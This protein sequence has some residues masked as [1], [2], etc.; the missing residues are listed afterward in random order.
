MSDEFL[1]ELEKSTNI[2]RTENN[3][4]TFQSTLN[5][6]LDWFSMS[7]GLRFQPEGR[8]ISLFMKAF[9]EDKQLAIKNLFF[10]RDIKKG[11]G[12][13]RVFRV[14][15][16][17]LAKTH[18]DIVRKN[19]VF[20]PFFGRWDDL[21]ELIDTP[22]ENSMW[23]FIKQQLSEDLKSENP[24]LLAKWLKSENTS[25][26]ESV[27]LAKKTRKA[28]S[29]TPKEYRKTLAELRKRID[30]LERRLSE[31]DYTFD[32][33]KVPSQAM[34]KY[35]KAFLRNDKDRYTQYIE[36]VIQGK[37]K[38][39]TNTLSAVQ[40]VRQ[41][42]ID[43]GK[44]SLEEKKHLDL[45]W[46]N[47]PKID[48]SENALVV[49]DTSGSMFYACG[50]YALGIAA[51]IGLALYYAENNKGIFHNRFITFSAKPKLQ[52]IQGKTIYE[53]V[54]FLENADWECNTDIEAVFT[55]I[56]NI[57][58]NKNLAQE[59]L[60]KKLYIVSDMEFDEAT[61]VSPDAPLFDAIRERY[62]NHG[63]EL[64]TLVFWNVSSRHN[65]IPVTKET[66]NV[67]LVS[68]MSQKIFENLIKNQL[69][70]PVEFMLE[71]LNNERYSVIQ[72]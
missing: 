47:I 4:L 10:T 43:R 8:I 40:I 39:N 12:E 14:V 15:L 28:L 51:S 52:K 1:N 36:K 54:K 7:G 45:L 13:R 30:V 63:Y 57:A 11:L 71:V 17:H 65:N 68:G 46:Q 34:L 9:Y 58:I 66:P 31:K 61:R 64:P 48:T 60:P 42:L 6:N 20:I 59:D 35:R 37:K 2:S 50:Q 29:M 41:I 70:D 3:A 44:M 26:K 27:K 62:K 69:P 25:S 56:L 19:I 22:V 16:K 53:K 18:P 49:A 33:E 23:F 32:Y 5:A 38:I 24:S 67:L 72:I 21:Y 55:L